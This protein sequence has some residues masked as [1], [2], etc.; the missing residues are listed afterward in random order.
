MIA[1]DLPN[2]VLKTI[3]LNEPHT[4]LN[5]STQ[6]AQKMVQEMELNKKIKTFDLL[7]QLVSMSKIGDLKGGLIMDAIL[8]DK[9]VISNVN[10]QEA[11]Q[12]TKKHQVV[13]QVILNHRRMHCLKSTLRMNM[14]Q[15]KI[16][17]G[18]IKETFKYISN[19]DTFAFTLKTNTM[20]LLDAHY[21]KDVEL[22]TNDPLLTSSQIMHYSTV[23]FNNINDLLNNMGKSLLKHFGC[24]FILHSTFQTLTLKNKYVYYKGTLDKVKNGINMILS[25]W[26]EL[27]NL[28]NN[29]N[30]MITQLKCIKE[31]E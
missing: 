24:Q 12:K 19:I 8:G 26:V 10:I 21:S 15:F 13:K 22:I 27:S 20:S 7:M 11:L 16:T 29:H 30:H 14:K 25:L 4:I 2:A 9:Y 23:M 1:T 17:G 28:T 3:T 18:R 5:S 31:H 6:T